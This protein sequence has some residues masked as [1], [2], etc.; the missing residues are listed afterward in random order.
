[1]RSDPPK[2]EQ[3]PPEGLAQFLQKMAN[4]DDPST[5]KERAKY[6]TYLEWAAQQAAAKRMCAQPK[7]AP[8]LVRHASATSEMLSEADEGAPMETDKIR[9]LQL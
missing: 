6:L 8:A 3:A 2:T 1:M 9:V 5:A 7:P 4:I